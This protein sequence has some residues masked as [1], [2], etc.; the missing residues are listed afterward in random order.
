MQR[1]LFLSR[2]AG[3][4]GGPPRRPAPTRTRFLAVLGAVVAGAVLL[5]AALV[6][7]LGGA[8]SPGTTGTSGSPGRT[9]GGG[10]ASE[11]DV[12][13]VIAQLVSVFEN[14]T[15]TIQYAYVEDLDD[16]RGYTAG[17]AGFC[18]ACGDLLTVVKNYTTRVPDNPLAGYVP[19][20]TGLAAAY[21]DS[22]R[23]LDGFRDAWRSAADDPVFRQVQDQ[24]TDAL[25]IA[26]ARK[27]ADANGV[28]SALGLA[29]LVDTAVEHGTQDG[30]DG[31]PSLVQ[32]TDADMGGSPADGVDET[33]WLRDFL[34]I[35]RSTLENPSS[36]DT[37]EVWSESVGRVDALG[38]LLDAGN[39][40][41]A[42][43]FT[44]NPWGDPQT[45]T[46]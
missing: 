46:G 21:D 36:S 8:G 40:D 20:L 37:S 31:L 4:A 19:T 10:A 24:V 41:L 30:P 18:T 44:V 9:S 28:R 16:G 17:R 45:I 11:R 26:P 22:T 12:D 2:E 14:G 13:Q 15:P 5:T 42:T 6:L 3:R 38:S 25:Y 29:I 33:E 1:T 43:P 7:L 35:R 27:L 32:K 23:G 34:D 39:L